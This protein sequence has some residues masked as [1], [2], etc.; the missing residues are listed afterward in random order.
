MEDESRS[1]IRRANRLPSNKQQTFSPRFLGRTLSCMRLAR[2]PGRFAATCRGVHRGRLRDATRKDRWEPQLAKVT[3]Y[4]CTSPLHIAAAML[5]L[6]HS[7]APAPALA[8]AP[9]HEAASQHAARAHAA[10]AFVKPRRTHLCN[11]S[12][13]FLENFGDTGLGN[14]HYFE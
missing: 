11:C 5:N 13:I 12:L 4:R 1:T 2:R 9:A 14:V 3:G 10:P 6:A 8:L 7:H